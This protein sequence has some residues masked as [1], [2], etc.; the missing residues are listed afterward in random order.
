MS[1]LYPSELVPIFRALRAPITGTPIPSLP[2]VAF[3][4][5]L[6]SHPVSIPYDDRPN[7][8]LV[9]DV[10]ARLYAE[11]QRLRRLLP[12]A[13]SGHHWEGQISSS[14]DWFDRAA[15]VTYRLR[16]RLVR[17]DGSDDG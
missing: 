7:R 15:S 9:R 14:D 13:P 17:D 16:Y 11:D 3:P 12:P 1:I 2:R 6:C 10:N 5:V 8:D 4:K